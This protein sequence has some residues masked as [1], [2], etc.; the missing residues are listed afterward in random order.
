MDGNDARGLILE[1]ETYR[2]RGAVFHVYQ[3]M[4][5]GFLE[6]VYQECLAIEMARRQIPF[7]AQCPIRLEYDGALLQQ[8]YFADFL[9]CGSI[10][11]ELKAARVLAAEHRAQLMNYMRAS[12]IQLGLINF[13]SSP[14]AQIERFIL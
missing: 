5:P 10:L 1:E 4:G 11:L 3:T 2:I 9:C 7:S 13:G 8:A 12:K 6:A 14:R